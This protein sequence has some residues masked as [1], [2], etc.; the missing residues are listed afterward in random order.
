MSDLVVAT[1]NWDAFMKS[2]MASGGGVLLA[3]YITQIAF[4]LIG[5]VSSIVGLIRGITNK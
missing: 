2:F 1:W 3:L 5:A 4:G